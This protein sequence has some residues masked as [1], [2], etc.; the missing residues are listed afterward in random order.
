MGGVCA[1]EERKE[2]TTLSWNI[3]GRFPRFR[4]MK[5]GSAG[6]KKGLRE[7]FAPCGWKGAAAWAAGQVT[8]GW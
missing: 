2:I 3:I 4:N 8:G 5:K 6:E 7:D 1:L